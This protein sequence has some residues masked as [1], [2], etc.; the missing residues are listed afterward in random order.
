MSPRRQRGAVAMSYRRRPS[1]QQRYHIIV[2]ENFAPSLPSTLF[3][4][5]PVVFFTSEMILRWAVGSNAQKESNDNIGDDENR[6]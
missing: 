6:R 4:A 1:A 2:L 3:L 5:W